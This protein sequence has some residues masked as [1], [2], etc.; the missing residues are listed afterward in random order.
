MTPQKRPSGIRI[1]LASAIAILPLTAAPREWKSADGSRTITAELIAHEAG[2]VTI[3]RTDGQEFTLKFSDLH[4]EEQ[5]WL[6]DNHP[7][8][9]APPP[10]E[11]IFDHLRFG[12]TR[13][14]VLAKLKASKAVEMTVDEAF[15]GR[16]GLNGAFRTRQKVGAYHATLYFDWTPAGLLKELTLQTEAVSSS[17]YNDGLKQSWV[18][19]SE[20][21]AILHGKP[22]QN[23]P[24]PALD[25]L[26]D[27]LFLASHLWR[28]P[29]GTAMLGTAQEGTHYMT[30]VRFTKERHEA[31]RIP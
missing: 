12:D 29:G 6:K 10:E 28:I 5:G 19:M 14:Q 13:D 22:I 30:V 25:S 9:E 20:L 17:H 26:D 23:G 8:P 18:A 3:R 21:L 4:E 24:L 31:R 11:A 2:K 16:V 27:G 15:L 1:V 7:D